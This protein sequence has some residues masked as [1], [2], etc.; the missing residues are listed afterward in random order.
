MALFSATRNHLASLLSWDRRTV[1]KRLREMGITHSGALSHGEVC[2]FLSVH[3][4]EKVPAE[5]RQL[6]LNL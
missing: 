6:K 3:Y 1:T 4:P 2:K 5:Y